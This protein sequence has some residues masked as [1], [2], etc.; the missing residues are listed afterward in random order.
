M[1]IHDS[2]VHIGQFR[3]LY[4]SPEGVFDFLDKLGVSRMA[5]SSTGTC[6][7]NPDVPIRELRRLIK[8]AGNRVTPVLWMNPEW[9]I[10]GSVDKLL[11][12]GIDWKCVKVHGYFSKW[13]DKPEVLQQTVNLAKRLKVPMLFH[14]GGRPE[15]DAGVYLPVA[16]SNPEV[17]FILAHSRPVDQTIKVMEECSNVMADTAFTPEEDVESMIKKGFANRILW[18]TDYPLHNVFYEGEDIVA[19]LND[20]ITAFK[21]MMTVEEWEMVSH[22]NYERVFGEM[23]G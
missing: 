23:N 4:S 7:G 8:V 13:E 6:E 15:S 12:C 10:D 17:T 18:G 19:N 22:T 9:M 1:I 16:K 11:S 20:R 21:K 3:E 5:A 14:T 2:H